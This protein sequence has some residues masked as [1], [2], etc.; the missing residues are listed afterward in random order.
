MPTFTLA[1]S[2]K[3]LHLL[4]AD[5]AGAGIDNATLEPILNR[6]LKTEILVTGT[7]CD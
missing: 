5:P 3:T 4:D 6:G 2:P 7:E 1:A